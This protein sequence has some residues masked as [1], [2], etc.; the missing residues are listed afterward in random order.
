MQHTNKYTRVHWRMVI[1]LAKCAEQR[2][3]Q[4]TVV[5][6]RYAIV[7]VSQMYFRFD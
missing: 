6:T 2:Q 7:K 3:Q 1:N 5:N 4:Q